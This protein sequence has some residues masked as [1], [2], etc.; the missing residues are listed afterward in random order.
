MVHGWEYGDER[1]EYN[2]VNWGAKDLVK[3]FLAKI[4]VGVFPTKGE[5]W[6]MPPMETAATGAPI[7]V[8]D[9]SGPS[10]YAGNHRDKFLLLDATTEPV[11]DFPFEWGYLGDWAKVDIRQLR[12]QMRWAYENRIEAHAMGKKASDYLHAEYTWQKSAQKLVDRLDQLA[13]KAHG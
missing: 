5:G 3:N 7:I 1:I 6:G 9:W 2:L 11:F 12:K 13:E 10:E 8:T 4:D